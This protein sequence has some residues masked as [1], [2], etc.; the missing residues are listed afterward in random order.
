MSQAE[1]SPTAHFITL[2]LA[3][4]R[5]AEP[6]PLSPSRARWWSP[7]PVRCNWIPL[8][9]S[10]VSASLQQDGEKLTV[11][12]RIMARVVDPVVT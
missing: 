1:G 5:M 11:G 9:S 12:R 6:S 2:P 4:V 3:R 7:V 8:V 10:L